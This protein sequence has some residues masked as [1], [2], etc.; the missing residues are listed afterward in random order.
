MVIVGP[1]AKTSVMT[2]YDADLIVGEQSKYSD[3]LSISDLYNTFRGTFPD[4]LQ[5][6]RPVEYPKLTD[7]AWIEADGG[8][9]LPDDVDIDVDTD[10]ERVQRLVWLHA[11]ERRRQA[12]LT[13]AYVP[14]AIEIE[15]GDWFERVGAKFGAGKLFEAIRVEYVVSKERGLYVVIHSKEVDPADVAWVEDMAADLSRPPVPDQEAEF[16]LL[17]PPELSVGALS[18]TEGGLTLP[19]IGVVIDNADDARIRTALIEVVPDGG[20]GIIQKTIDAGPDPLTANGVAISEGI[21]PGVIYQVRARFMGIVKPSA[22]SAVYYVTTTTDYIV[23]AATSAAPGSELDDKLDRVSRELDKLSDNFPGFS[24]IGG[25]GTIDIEANVVNA[26]DIQVSEGYIAHPTLGRIDVDETI[27]DTAW[28]AL[29]APPKGY[30][31]IA[32]SVEPVDERFD[33]AAGEGHF[34]AFAYDTDNT[35]VRA[36]S[37]DRNA[38][39]IF[40]P[41][42]TDVVVGRFDKPLAIGSDELSSADGITNVETYIRI[43][44]DMA[45]RIESLEAISGDGSAAIT[46]LTLALASEVATRASQ[47][48]TL[49]TN[50]GITNANVATNTTAISTE[51]AARASADSTLTANLGTATANIAT[52]T[53]AIATEAAARASADSTLTTNLGIANAAITTNATAISTETAARASADT[54]LTTNLG[55][56]SSSVSVISSSLTSL[57]GRVSAFWGVKVAAGTNIASIEAMASGGGVPSTVIINAGQIQMNGAVLINGSVSA[58]KLAVSQLSAITADVGLLRT[59]SSGA[60]ME[61]EANQLR[62]YDSSGTLRARFGVW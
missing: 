36:Y 59:A 9:E 32:Y 44:T 39:E 31:G 49:T 27:F 20:G 54:T 14:A 11:Q 6:F 7:A 33:N 24:I 22:W 34:F 46:T 57:D 8:D 51:A 55:S 38:G 37:L 29:Y 10:E 12:R 41:R 45:A 3:K 13:E 21:A 53:T 61:M 18:V 42:Q 4:P 19:T 17:E 40:I 47:T 62:A 43:D 56:L 2:L 16:A 30:G 26:S 52:N 28:G 48:T 23:P 35:T 60:R 15:N 25:P 50:L 1:Q 58:A 5:Q